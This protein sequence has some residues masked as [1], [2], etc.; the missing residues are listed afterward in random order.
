MSAIQDTVISGGSGAS[1]GGIE[2][3]TVMI[4]ASTVILPQ[5]SIAV[6][7]RV[8]ILGQEFPSLVV[9]AGDEPEAPQLSNQNFGG[10]GGGTLL[11]HATVISA[12]SAEEKTGEIMS[13]MRILCK[14]FAVLPQASLI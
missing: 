5:E 6:Q 7:V 9:T 4:C 8:S 1:T 12:G 2:S 13:F 14:I 3:L 10:P 11:M